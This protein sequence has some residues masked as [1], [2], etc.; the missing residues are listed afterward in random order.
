MTS[1]NVKQ[2]VISFKDKVYNTLNFS[3]LK[4]DK[5][6]YYP[7]TDT[8]FDQFQ[9][10][11][12]GLK[13]LGFNP[14]MRSDKQQNEFLLIK[15]SEYC[16]PRNE[17]ICPPL[18]TEFWEPKVKPVNSI[19]KINM[20]SSKPNKVQKKSHVEDEIN[21]VVHVDFKTKRK[22]KSV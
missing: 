2:S 4:N 15:L 19:P 12:Y 22:L 7:I 13:K 8:P 21:T 1:N 16:G 20:V 3:I 11:F 6:L 17:I 18:C 14:Q 10:V 5:I 9:D